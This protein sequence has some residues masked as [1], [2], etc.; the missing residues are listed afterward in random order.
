MRLKSLW[1][2]GASWLVLPLGYVFWRIRT[3]S[4]AL[5]NQKVAPSRGTL[6]AGDDKNRPPEDTPDEATND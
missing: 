6:R 3:P 5:L 1:P 4:R 2:V